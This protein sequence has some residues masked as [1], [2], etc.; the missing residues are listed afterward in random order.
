MI[1]F[2]FVFFYFCSCSFFVFEREFN[3]FF[4]CVYLLFLCTF[5]TFYI[6]SNDF[7]WNILSHLPFLTEGDGDCRQNR[8][9]YNGAGDNILKILNASGKLHPVFNDCKNQD[10]QIEIADRYTLFRLALL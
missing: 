3:Y 1:L 7:L 2:Y 4:K 9:K 5:F 10:A 8:E 6:I